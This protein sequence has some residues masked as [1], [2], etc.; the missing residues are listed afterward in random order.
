VTAPKVR[1]VV[2]DTGRVDSPAE[3]QFALTVGIHEDDAAR[4]HPAE[5]GG[6]PLTLG[7]LGAIHEFGTE[8]IPARSPFRGWFDE[9]GA[10]VQSEIGAALAKMALKQQW[11][12]PGGMKDVARRARNTLVA[13]IA[14]HIA[15]ELA[16]STLAKKAPK[17]VPLIDS[18][19]FVDSISI[20]LQSAPGQ[21][22]TRGRRVNWDYK[23]AAGGAGKGGTK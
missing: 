23:A 13:R 2:K 8:T 19:A 10:A 14:K 5:N 9:Q 1:I 20:Q 4:Q 22:D 12:G 3:V 7:E 18:R 15:P 17:I 11:S 21:V 16:E 6:R